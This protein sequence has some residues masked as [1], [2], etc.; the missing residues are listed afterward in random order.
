MLLLLYIGCPAD[1]KRSVCVFAAYI[2]LDNSI[3]GTRRRGARR[4][5]RSRVRGLMGENKRIPMPPEAAAGFSCLKFTHKSAHKQ[6][7]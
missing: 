2:Y 7:S 1:V 5:P 3:R 4:A 6:R